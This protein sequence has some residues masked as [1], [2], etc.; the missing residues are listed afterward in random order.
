MK[1]LLLLIAFIAQVAASFSQVANYTY[2]VGSETYTPITGGT[3]IASVSFD[4]FNSAAIPL[5]FSYNCTPV[6]S[7]RINADG[8]IGLGTY[9]STANYTPLSGT[10]NGSIGILSVFGR[11]MANSTVGTPEIRYETVGNEFIAQWTDV[12]RSGTTGERIS[13]QIRINTVTNVI[14]YVYGSYTAGLANVNYPE[15]G[16]K[17]INN[18]FATNIKNVTLACGATGWSGMT[19]GT[20]NNSKVCISSPTV[21][22]SGTSITWFPP[23]V[24][25]PAAITGTAAQ[26]PGLT[27]QTYSVPTVAG[28][29]S[30]TWTVPTGWTVTAGAG[31]NSITVTTGTAGQNG[32]ISV[33]A[34]S[35][36][37]TS[38]PSTVAVTVGNDT[39][40]TPGT[41]TG[42]ATQCPALT[43]QT[44]SIAAVTNATTA[45]ARRDKRTQRS[46][47]R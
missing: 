33:T 24:A 38:S 8:H 14:K 7:I 20:A 34:S 22:A 25:T 3:V 31:T 19:P 46:C 26:C 36:C 5:S 39:P 4:A 29:T 10:I 37:G 43:G 2:S 21:P 27:G 23:T 6:T 44:Y 42:S 15:I 13:F 18:V 35:A 47:F 16:L 45:D 17:G 41:I 12:S 40:A 28:A 30:Y 32:N 1:K 11:D 9:I